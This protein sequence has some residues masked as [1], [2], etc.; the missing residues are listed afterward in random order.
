MPFINYFAKTPEF[1]FW[2]ESGGSL[3]ETS[4]IYF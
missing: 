1:L 2:Q 3:A 4:L